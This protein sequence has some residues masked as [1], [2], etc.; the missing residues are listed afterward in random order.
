VRCA[1]ALTIV[2]ELARGLARWARL[3]SRKIGS[4]DVTKTYT[5]IESGSVPTRLEERFIAI[6]KTRQGR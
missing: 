3:K 4:A 2:L 5:D 6:I 1:E